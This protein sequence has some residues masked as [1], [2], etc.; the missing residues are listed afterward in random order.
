[1]PSQTD[2]PPAQTEPADFGF[3]LNQQQP[4]APTSPTARFAK[5]GKPAKLLILALIALI[6]VI[7][8]ALI[9]SG[10]DKNSNQVL[11][12]MTQN[13]EIVRVSQLQDQKFTDANTKGLSATT[14]SVMSSQK[15]EL[16]D[17]LA[18]AKVK[19]G[20]QQL[21]TGL[22]K[23]TD[24]ELEAAAKNNNLDQAYISYL[25]TSMVEYL[26]SLNE[27][28]QATKSKTLK[29]T[30]QSAYDSI[31]TLLKSPQFKSA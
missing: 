9:F 1:M 27:T 28:F 14:Q 13:Q 6:I 11:N 20:E 16:A 5:F 31:Q 30:L 2:Q 25:K 18:K 3:M 10:G 4:P 24:T 19:Y 21:A 22:N 23:N 8:V 26:N 29:S 7:V 17:Y 15:V 12:L